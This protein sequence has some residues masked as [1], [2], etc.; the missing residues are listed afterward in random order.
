[1]F[2]VA[3]GIPFVTD[4]PTGLS[5]LYTNYIGVFPAKLTP[6]QKKIEFR[7]FVTKG[8]GFV[9]KLI[10]RFECICFLSQTNGILKEGE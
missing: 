1:M 6:F 10:A 9:T 8:I 4:Q 2:P 3:K 7:L 5:I